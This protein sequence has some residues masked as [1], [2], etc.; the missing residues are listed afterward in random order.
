MCQR[1]LLALLDILIQSKYCF[2]SYASINISP[3]CYLIIVTENFIC[4]NFYAMLF[5][6]YQTNWL[7]EKS[8]IYSFGIV[9]LEI[10]TNRPIIQQSR[11]KP[12]L[13]EW[14]SFMIT[15]GDI[16]SIMDPNLHQNYD[17]GSVWKAIEISMSCL[18]PSSIG[19]PNM[20]QVT[21]GLKEC[22]ISE[23]SRISESRDVELRTSMD[24][25]KDMYTEVIPEA[26]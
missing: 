2:T 18:S 21:K 4:F 22:L 15:K 16:G 17:I 14:V 3:F 5:R 25:S 19:R 13:V 9:L 26:R 20:S 12:H 7:T 10:I 11:E 24:Y 6:Y 1:L 8:D 23:N